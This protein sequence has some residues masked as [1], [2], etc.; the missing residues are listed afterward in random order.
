[1]NSGY[2]NADIFCS[3]KT[4]C[5][6]PKVF[7]ISDV[8]PKTSSTMKLTK[9]KILWIFRQKEK[10]ASSG[11]IAKIQH[12]TRRRVDQ[13]WKQYRETGVIPVIGVAMGR[14]KKPVAVEE[15][16]VIE[17][18]YQ[19][20]RYGARMLENLIEQVYSVIIS[21]NRIHRYLMDRGLA[22]DEASK[23][24]QRKW[25]RYERAHSMSAG[26]I[27]W[28]EDAVSGH[29]ICAVLDDSSR[30][31]LAIDEFATVNTENTIAVVE[32]AIQEYGAICP[33]REL[34]MDH[35]SEFGAHRRDENGDWDSEF[36]QYLESKGIHPIQA[37]VK[38]PQTKR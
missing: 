34:I 3:G 12:I 24:K 29:K 19:R 36:K 28:H 26:H 16:T 10:K 20:F 2:T 15:S 5:I 9:K 37:R 6:V 7:P 8:E 21:H 31:V 1:M 23:R 33:L 18:A 11:V 27:D 13:L 35:G 38:H 22:K 25:V 14:P 4:V 30:K 17:E 32:R